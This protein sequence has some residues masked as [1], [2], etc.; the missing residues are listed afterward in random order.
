[1][2]NLNSIMASIEKNSGTQKTASENAE[3]KTPSKSALETVVNKVAEEVLPEAKTAAPVEDNADAVDALTKV[4][5]RLMGADQDAQVAEAQMLGN[6]FADAA[7]SK[8]ASF[9]AQVAEKTA[10]VQPATAGVDP[11]TLVKIAAEIGYQDTR[12]RLMKL[13][14]EEEAKEECDKKD[15]D[16]EKKD[17]KKEVPAFLKKKED[18]SEDKSDDEK[19]A[20]EFDKGFVDAAQQIKVAA[21]VE[22]LK[23]AA[24]AE[25]IVNQM[26]AAG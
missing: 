18:K 24:I 14:A 6:A 8:L 2:A 10:A 9:E 15:C 13:A 12:G 4:A 3:E 5:A 23:G 16:K 22:F 20:A 7:I 26:T 1:M 11:D 17:D 21:E 19:T 25:A